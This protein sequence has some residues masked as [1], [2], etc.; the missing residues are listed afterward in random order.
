[1]SILKKT[2]IVMFSVLLLFSCREVP[3]Q[4]SKTLANQIEKEVQSLLTQEAKRAFLE[5][6]IEDDQR[7]RDGALSADL[8]LKYG[9]NSKE[10]RAY[11]EAQIQQDALNLEK[12]EMYLKYYGHP[13]IELGSDA[14]SAPWMVIHHAQ[15][16]EARERNF[17]LLY[18]AYKNGIIDDGAMSFYLGRMH[19]IKTGERFDMEG[20]YTGEDEINA[21]IET[22]G[23]SLDE[24]N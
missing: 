16:Y 3:P 13:G 14:V 20:P 10:H 7:V 15:G 2:F 24:S 19:R 1:M 22:L 4:I 8:V 17:P 12:I 5:K 6:I 9:H 11:I 23:L 21:L 18:R